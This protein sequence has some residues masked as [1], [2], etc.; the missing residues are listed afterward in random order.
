MVS[1]AVNSSEGNYV[2][3][4]R[5][6][7]RKGLLALI[8][9]LL[10]AG[11]GVYYW[12]QNDETVVESQPLITLAQIGDIENTIAATGSLKPFETVE[13]GAQVSGQLLKLYVEAGDQVEAAHC[14]NRCPA[15]APES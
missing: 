10:V 7:G 6:K 11:G 8:L 15:A 14:R 4:R 2:P 9:L 12:L 3:Q 13:V 1:E 5:K